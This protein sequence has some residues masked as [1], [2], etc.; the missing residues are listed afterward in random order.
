M[1]FPPFSYKDVGF[2]KSDERM[3]KREQDVVQEEGYATVSQIFTVLRV[4][5]V[6]ILIQSPVR[7]TLSQRFGLGVF[8]CLL[9]Y[10]PNQ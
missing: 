4:F 8:F 10:F 7:Q 2:H 9:L 6:N 1:I 5:N 3:K